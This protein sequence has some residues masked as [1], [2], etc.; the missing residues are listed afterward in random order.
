LERRASTEKL[1]TIYTVIIVNWSFT[2]V[3]G[4]RLS[5]VFTVDPRVDCYSLNCSIVTQMKQTAKLPSSVCVDSFR[6]QKYSYKNV[7]RVNTD[8]RFKCT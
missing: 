8:F 6:Q 4:V 2:V 3:R 5:A 7:H 1:Y